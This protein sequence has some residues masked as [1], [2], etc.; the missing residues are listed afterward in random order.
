MSNI[1]GFTAPGFEPVADA[2]EENFNQGLE[3]GAGFAAYIG[4]ELIIEELLDGAGRDAAR[5]LV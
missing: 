3:L 1:A 2:F 5:L 4:N